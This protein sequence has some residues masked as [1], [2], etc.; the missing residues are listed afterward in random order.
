MSEGFGVAEALAAITASDVRWRAPESRT[1]EPTFS[2]PALEGFA[3]AL[4]FTAERRPAWIET[5][6][7]DGMDDF[8]EVQIRALTERS[9]AVLTAFWAPG[10]STPRSTVLLR[11]LRL[12]RG[13]EVDGFQHDD[14]GRVVGCTITLVFGD[15]SIQLGG[16][17]GADRTALPRLL[18]ALRSALEG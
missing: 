10:A 11:P 8:R 5:V 7:T 16:S 18:P 2:P 4:A 9:V 6:A 17:P 13:L 12:L 14:G 1:V 15:L 3:Q